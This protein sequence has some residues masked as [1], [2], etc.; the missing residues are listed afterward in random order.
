MFA[1]G[2]PR[3]T[4]RLGPSLTMPVTAWPQV[5]SGTPSTSAS[6]TR[7][8]RFQRFLDFLR[9]HFFAGGIDA[10][11]AAAEKRDRAVRFHA[12]EIAGNRIAHDCRWCG[13]CARFSPHPC[14]SRPAMDRPA[15][16]SPALPLPGGIGPVVLVDD[17]GIFDASVKAAVCVSPSLVMIES[18]H[19]HRFGRT[20]NCRSARDAA[21]GRGGRV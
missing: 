17:D 9:V 12:R 5:S 16:T 14:N 15:R 20:R 13:T 10:I 18:A 4:R 1:Q 3:R 7:G 8:M 6:S 19:A 2:L 21:G 11:A